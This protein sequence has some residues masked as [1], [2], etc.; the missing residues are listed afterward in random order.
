MG[1]APPPHDSEQKPGEEEHRSERMP[2]EK[3]PQVPSRGRNHDEWFLDTARWIC[4]YFFQKA[5]RRE[6][7]YTANNSE[8]D[9]EH[10][11]A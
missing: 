8:Q 3:G 4:S 5:R 1:A 2:Q 10:I 7:K 6:S 11:A 9:E